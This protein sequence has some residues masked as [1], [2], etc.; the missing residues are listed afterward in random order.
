MSF[1][2]GCNVGVVVHNG[3]LTHRCTLYG[4]MNTG[5]RRGRRRLIHD[6]HKRRRCRWG[7]GLDGRLHDQMEVRHRRRRRWSRARDVHSNSSTGPRGCRCIHCLHNDWH[8]AGRLRCLHSRLKVSG[9][10]SQLSHIMRGDL[11][12]ELRSELRHLICCLLPFRLRRKMHLLSHCSLLNAS[13]RRLV[14]LLLLLWS[15]E[16]ERGR[17]PRVL[18][19]SPSCLLGFGTELDIDRQRN[20]VVLGC[21]W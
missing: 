12:W 13:P 15:W 17:N 2:A 3:W 19:S 16:M 18:V 4:H 5:R 1:K 7:W 10:R 11:R 9:W 20:T 21:G 8:L 6:N 14:L